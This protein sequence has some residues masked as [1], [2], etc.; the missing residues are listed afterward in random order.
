MLQQGLFVADVC[1]YYGDHV[2]NFTQLKSSDPA[3]IL[4]GYDYDVVTAEVLLTRMQVKDGRLV[5]P[6]GMSYRVLVLP[7]RRA[8]SLPVLR[9]IRALVEAGA[10]VAG[11]R[12]GEA[13]GLVGYPTSDAEVSRLAG[14]LWGPSVRPGEPGEHRLGQGRIITGRTAREVLEADGVVP[15]F[16]H[17]G[18]P[19]DAD[20]DFIHR[21]DGGT[22]IYFVA[23]RAPRPEAVRCLFRVAGRA[24][25]LWCAVTGE[26]RFAPACREEKGRTAVPLEFPPCGSWFVVFRAPASEHRAT[27]E[28]NAPEFQPQEELE[29]P[30]TVKFDPRWGGPK[31]AEFPK[32]V[33][34]SERSEPGIRF[35]SGCATYA[36]RFDLPEGLR[37]PGRRLWLDL[38]DLR[39][40]AGVR[41]NGRNLGIVWAPPFRVDITD[42]VRPADNALEVDVVNFWPNRIIGDHSLPP[43]KRFTRTNIRKLTKDTPLMR[44]GLFGPVRFYTSSR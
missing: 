2:P 3:G 14:E 12:P 10:T 6:D 18:G 23:N 7:D 24:P 21:R 38:G 16:E 8:I 28:K 40:L 36:R 44:S 15:D 37:A 13:T 25:E 27:G 35:Y 43:E 20:L 30:W 29:G 11:T 32:L 31:A 5:L 1:Y 22:D 9:K 19:E 33:S 4:P 17:R 39:E 34:W 41:V 26:R 42:C